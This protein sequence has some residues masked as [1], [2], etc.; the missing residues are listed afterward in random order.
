MVQHPGLTISGVVMVALPHI[1]LSPAIM[2]PKKQPLSVRSS[3]KDKRKTSQGDKGPAT[4]T[5]QS[6]PVTLTQTI[7]QDVHQQSITD[8]S[9][10]L[11]GSPSAS[12]VCPIRVQ[13]AG[14]HTPFLRYGLPLANQPPAQW[15]G[16]WG[17]PPWTQYY[18]QWP[19]L[20]PPAAPNGQNSVNSQQSSNLP[21]GQPSAQQANHPPVAY[22]NTHSDDTQGHQTDQPHQELEDPLMNT[23]AVSTVPG[24]QQEPI[25]SMHVSQSLKSAFGLGNTLI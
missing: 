1:S 15:W 5:P 7:H 11:S 12:S 2:P 4:K 6:T 16:P 25:L 8:A 19:T 9:A 18:Q 13:H 17:P 10:S 24:K 23:L 3:T 22:Y 21:Q 14:S 20:P